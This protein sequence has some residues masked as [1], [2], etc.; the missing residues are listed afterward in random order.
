MHVDVL[1]LVILHFSHAHVAVISV[2]LPRQASK[3]P[4]VP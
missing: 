1:W 3:L 4:S 2:F